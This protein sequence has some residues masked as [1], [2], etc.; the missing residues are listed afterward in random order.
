M[1]THLNTTFSLPERLL[2]LG[3]SGFVGK[4]IQKHYQGSNM[5]V[6]GLSS[7]DLDLD[8]SESVAK[9]VKQIRPTDCVLIL[10]ALTPDKGRGVTTLMKNLRMIENITS[11]LGTVQPQHLI[12]F[13]SDA[14]YPLSN[15]LI[16]EETPSDA[17]DLYGI[18]HRTRE[19]MLE[20]CFD[21]ICILRPS[22]IYGNGDTH[23]SYGPNRFRRLAESEQKI[24]IGG[25]GEETRDHVFIDDVAEIVNLVIG[26][27]SVGLLNIATGTSTSFKV[28]AEEVAS[29][30]KENVEICPT[31][32]TMP[33]RHRNFDISAIHKAYPHFIMTDLVKGLDSIK[34]RI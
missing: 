7:K 21:K 3:G 6:L 16:N 20:S 18:M 22:L 32:R 10:S 25:N 19:L 29:R 28:V 15:A 31:P 2:I 12:Y 4:A 14:V 23:N 11:A 9:L 17:D 30:V 24:T 26:H 13:S 1:L 33:I 34:K 8:S 5:D 27:Q